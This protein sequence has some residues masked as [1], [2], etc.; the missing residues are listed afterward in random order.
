MTA[1]EARSAIRRGEWRLPTAGLAPAHAQANLVMLPREHAYDF[2]LF[3]QRNPRPCPLL[4]VT[5]PGAYE[6]DCARGGDLRT[7]LPRYRLFRDGAIA[8]ELDDLLSVFRE[9][10]VSFLIGCSFSFEAALLDEGLEVRHISEGRNVPMYRTCR[11]TIPAGPF[12]GPLVV[13]M[14]PFPPA[15]VASAIAI[16]ARVPRVHGAP[17]HVGDPAALGIADLA[18]PDYGEAVTVRAGE[19]PLFWACGVT[20]QAALVGARLPFALTQAPGYMLVTDIPC[21]GPFPGEMI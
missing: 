5:D 11:S 19:V 17:M 6:P 1:Q 14:R 2:L 9:D 13:S 16:T 7:D 8:A 18:R 15:Q 21:G 20:P 4:E 10:L 3:C 12:G